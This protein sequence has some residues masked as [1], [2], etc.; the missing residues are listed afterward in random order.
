MTLD[1]IAIHLGVGHQSINK[2][3]CAHGAQDSHDGM[4]FH[5]AYTIFQSWHISQDD[6]RPGTGN[7]QA[8]SGTHIQSTSN[9]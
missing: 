4:Y 2:N 9:V 1:G 3:L 8:E 7:Q 5:T 6:L